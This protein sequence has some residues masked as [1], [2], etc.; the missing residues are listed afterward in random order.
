M[1]ALLHLSPSLRIALR[2]AQGAAAPR[3]PFAAA[4]SADGRAA[5]TLVIDLDETLLFRPRGAL[6]ALA[7][8]LAPARL[9]AAL[10]GQPYA[11]A[12]AAVARLAQRFRVVAVTARWGP[13]AAEPTAC[14]LERHGL[15]GL[16]IVLAAGMHPRDASR[17]AYKLAAVELLREEGWEPAVGVGDRPS[18]LEA[19]AASG[20][21]AIM[22]AHAQ[23][24]PRGHALR[25]LQGVAR[26]EQRLVAEGVLQQR[27]PAPGSASNRDRATVY[28][29]DDADVHTG[30]GA[31]AFEG[32]E[33]LPVSL[34][35]P[36]TG[37]AA[38]PP[39]WAQ[40][41]ELLK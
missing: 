41:E 36:A 28:L 3:N 10:V 17:A 2:A 6:D 33:P 12:T 23:G 30:G 32:L 37:A 38:M 40:I 18:D 21:R 11:G 35:P 34:S 14:W 31:G 8:Y 5:P 16:P 1:S 20:L 19:Y 15:A 13:G 25:A 27:T 24:A 29:S 39:V 26:A 9:S 4:R 22:V 7:L